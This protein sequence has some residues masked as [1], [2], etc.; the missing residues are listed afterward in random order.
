MGD[1]KLI[2]CNVLESY[3]LVSRVFFNVIWNV[4]CIDSFIQETFIGSVF[5][6][7]T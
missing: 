7:G 3:F 1:I 5:V 4:G 2:M 6:H